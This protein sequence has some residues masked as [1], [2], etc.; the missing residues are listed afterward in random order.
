MRYSFMNRL[1][2]IDWEKSNKKV[3]TAVKK[4][5]DLSDKYRA[6]AEYKSVSVLLNSGAWGCEKT[7][8]LSNI[9][10][11]RTIMILTGV[12]CLNKPITKIPG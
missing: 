5:P 12:F 11:T 8:S 7:G 2:I 1:S 3:S 9:P 6:M 4:G 10:N